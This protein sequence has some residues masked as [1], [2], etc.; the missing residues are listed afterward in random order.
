[1]KRR[2]LALLTAWILAFACVGVG[3]ASE[4]EQSDPAESTVTAAKEDAA[5]GDSTTGEEEDADVTVKGKLIEVSLQT[6]SSHARANYNRL[7]SALKKLGRDNF[8]L[9]SPDPLLILLTASPPSLS[10]RITAI[11]AAAPSHGPQSPSR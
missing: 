2:V 3:F 5:D 6:G 1:M 11:Q 7:S 9:L 4:A 10:Q 8:T